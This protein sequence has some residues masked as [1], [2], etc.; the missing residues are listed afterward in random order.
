MSSNRLKY[1]EC[2]M[3][4]E[5]IDNERQLNYVIYKKKNVS[6]KKTDA[7]S[8]LLGITRK[9]TNCRSGKFHP[10]ASD[11][12]TS[13]YQ[14]TGRLVEH[15]D[16][17]QVSLNPLYNNTLDEEYNYVNKKTHYVPP[18]APYKKGDKQMCTIM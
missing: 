8:E 18:P 7:E 16:Y 3:K 15:Y 5:N 1:D 10:T 13:T 4:Q 11:K 9:N 2:S 6:K 12:Y 14:E 17:P